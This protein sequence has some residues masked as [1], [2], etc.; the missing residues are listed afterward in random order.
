[1]RLIKF[2]RTPVGSGFPLPCTY[3]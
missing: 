1:M 2:F 3:C